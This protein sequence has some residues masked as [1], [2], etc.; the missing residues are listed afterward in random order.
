MQTQV[1][2]W[3]NSLALRIPKTFA[4]EMAIIQDTAVEISIVEGKLIVTPLSEAKTYSLDNLLSQITAENLHREV[5]TGDAV[6]NE[7]W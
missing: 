3:G 1:K 7:V 4:E 2:K 5:D 6:G